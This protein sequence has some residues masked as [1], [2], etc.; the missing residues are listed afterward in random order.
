MSGKQ[1]VAVVAIASV[2]LSAIF[3]GAWSIVVAF[4]AVIAAIGALE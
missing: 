3:A 1:W 4:P 2:A